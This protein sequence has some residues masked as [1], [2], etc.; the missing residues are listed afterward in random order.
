MAT[1][2]FS[3][4]LQ[5]SFR[6]IP[7]FSEPS[8]HRNKRR[9]RS[10]SRHWIWAS[11]QGLVDL[12]EPVQ[13]RHRRCLEEHH[14]SVVF[15][16]SNK[17]Q[18]TQC[19]I[20]VKKTA[21]FCSSCG[22]NLQANAWQTRPWHRSNSNNYRS[23]RSTSR[24]RHQDLEANNVPEPVGAPPRRSALRSP[25]QRRQDTVLRVNIHSESDTDGAAGQNRPFN[26][27]R[28]SWSSWRAWSPAR[29]TQLKPK[30]EQQSSSSTPNAQTETGILKGQISA[31]LGAFEKLCIHTNT[32]LPLEMQ[33]QL[34]QI[35][36]SVAPNAATGKDMQTLAGTLE[37]TQKEIKN[38]L[39][40]HHSEKATWEKY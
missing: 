19:N 7:A 11:N 3:D 1:T 35:Q 8:W 2:S 9:R 18:C 14:S 26:S 25:S 5:H 27:S 17:M 22:Q 10:V 6:A 39:D 36:A 34:Q 38:I 24:G 13:Q 32:S 31:L 20:Y 4:P 21:T 23:Q 37:N 29:Q 28:S 12:P 33:Q 16:E 40:K 15:T 30:N